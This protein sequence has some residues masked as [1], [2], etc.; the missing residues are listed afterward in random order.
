MII[1][2]DSGSTKT[3]WCIIEPEGGKTF[4]QTSGLNPVIMEEDLFRQKITT[5]LM[6]H[7][8]CIYDVYQIDFFGAGC[9]PEKSSIVKNIFQSIFPHAYQIRVASDMLG[10]AIALCGHEP[11]I[12]AI[13]GTGSNSCLYDGK[14]IVQHTPCL[15]YIIGDE[16][17]SA[18]LGKHFINAILKNTM[19]LDLCDKFLTETGFTQESILNNVY[20]GKSPNR[21][22]ASFSPFIH[23]HLYVPEVRNLVVSNFQSFFRNNIWQYGHPE[24]PVNFVGSMAF[25]YKDCL[26]EAAQK[27]GFVIG[28]MLKSPI[29]GLV[30]KII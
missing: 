7:V 5:E 16:G 15:G 30:G 12:A 10:A 2:A 20:R 17:G 3:D 1:I 9:T 19:P 22:L 18:V 26:Q 29:E 25:H 4:F 21:F 28:N 24:M 8:F 14:N 23:Q 13:L 11:G 27:E 6:P